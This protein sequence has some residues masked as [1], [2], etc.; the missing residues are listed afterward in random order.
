MEFQYY[1]D[2]SFVESDKLAVLWDYPA[3]SYGIFTGNNP[4][5]GSFPSTQVLKQTVDI[6]TA[7]DFSIFVTF[8]SYVVSSPEEFRHRTQILFSNSDGDDGWDF[9]IL[10]SNIFFVSNPDGELYSFDNIWI[11]E[12]NCV[13]IQKSGQTFTV[14]KYDVM[15]GEIIA[16]QSVSFTLT[17]N[18]LSGP[19]H[20]A[21]NADTFIDSYWYSWYGVIEQLAIVT[22]T[23]DRA[24]ISYLFQGF[25]P[26]TITETTTNALTVFDYS[27]RPPLEEIPTIYL[28]I[29]QPIIN[30]ITNRVN[31]IP[32]GHYYGLFYA[33]ALTNIS[34]G[35][36]F[37]ESYTSC[38]GS[39]TAYL[40]SYNS[41]SGLLAGMQ[42]SGW[43]VSDTIRSNK[44]RAGGVDLFSDELLITHNFKIDSHSGEL[45]KLA[46]D[47]LY[48]VDKESTSLSISEDTSYYTGFYM[49]GVS[50]KVN[51][52]NVT[53]LGYLPNSA[54]NEVNII[55]KFDSI[56]ERFKVE[57]AG[58][59]YY[60]NGLKVPTADI[61]YDGEYVD[62]VSVTET[63]SDEFIY[64]LA[65]DLNLLSLGLSGCAT[66]RF[67]PLTSTPYSGESSY[68]IMYRMYPNDFVETSKLHMFHGMPVFYKGTGNQFNNSNDYWQ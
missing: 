46:Y 38:A 48:K 19:I 33:E 27:W 49:D 2:N 47:V 66:G 17:P 8:K 44:Y 59:Y 58:A 43:N 52:N 14:Y 29:C 23:L 22:E 26:T 24:L 45:Y 6:G 60:Y 28:D 35:A 67:Y 10:A 63:N 7:E 53:L 39:G 65:G 20:I 62:L 31:T 51:T 37:A 40:M 25:R 1:F 12:K 18:L 34:G 3:T 4:T 64:D 54:P 61:T 30:D 15:S 32:S 42:G 57:N 55:G 36:T 13:C 16:E 5:V 9:G 50:V 68:D 21:Y 56:S 41:P 11:G